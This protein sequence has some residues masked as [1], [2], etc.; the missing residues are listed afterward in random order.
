AELGRMH[1]FKD[2]GNG[3]VE[4][5]VLKQN[6]FKNEIQIFEDKIPKDKISIPSEF[7]EHFTIDLKKLLICQENINQDLYN[8]G[9]I[10]HYSGINIT[11]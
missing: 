7:L 10:S 3:T 9:D 1:D 5:K 2:L 6:N 8:N 11:K 4:I